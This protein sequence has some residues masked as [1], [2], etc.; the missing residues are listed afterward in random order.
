MPYSPATYEEKPYNCCI[1]CRYIGKRCDGPDFLA[2]EIPRLCEWARLRKAYLTS[3]DKKWTNNYIAEQADISRATADR[4]FAGDIDDLK[5]TTASRIL[6]VLVNGTWGQ[7]PCAMVADNGSDNDCEHF[8]ELLAT[9]RQ[10]TD[11]LKKQVEFKEKQMLAKD[12]L[13]AD[14]KNFLHLKNKTIQI[15]AVL[16]GLCVVVIIGSLVMDLLNPSV[17]YFWLR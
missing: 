16:L 8:K 13:L 10:K 12:G 17:G 15:L 4:F 6:K 14:L 2:M 11:Y 3:Q 7:Y 5:F 1:D 9:E